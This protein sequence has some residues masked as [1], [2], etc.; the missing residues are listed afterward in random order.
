MEQSIFSGGIFSFFFFFVMEYE[1]NI[2]VLKW[3]RLLDKYFSIGIN[4][5]FLLQ[6]Q[7]KK[8]PVFQVSKF[9]NYI[10]IL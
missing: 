9:K 4:N 5:I 7:E 8:I 10:K 6:T 3:I 2:S 1:K